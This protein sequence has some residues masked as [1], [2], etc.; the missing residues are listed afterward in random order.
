MKFKVFKNLI[1]CALLLS[2]TDAME[3]GESKCPRFAFEQKLLE[4]LVRLEHSVK[5][6][7]SKITSLEERMLNLE[8]GGKNCRNAIAFTTVL[9]RETTFE[10]GN[11]IK[12]NSV[13][14]NEGN[15]YNRN[16][17]MFRAPISGTYIF[18]FQI[19]HWDTKEIT[20][21]LMLENVLQ[22]SAIINPGGKS[23]QA[24]GHAVVT[25]LSGQY[26]WVQTTGGKLYGSDTFYGTAF[27]G[28]FLY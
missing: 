20:G 18:A 17:G 6:I 2:S 26:V 16:S 25:L 9:S 14:N 12:F 22:S 8:N 24:T 4:S 5:T 10:S 19:E 28:A 1:F 21:Q 13:L 7:G 11:I 15:G 23:T 27:S 3:S